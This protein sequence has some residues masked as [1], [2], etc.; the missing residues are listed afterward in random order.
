MV[1]SQLQRE[2]TPL[3]LRRN[4]RKEGKDKKQDEKFT[5]AVGTKIR[6]LPK[7]QNTTICRDL[8]LL[9]LLRSYKQKLGAN[10]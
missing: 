7:L 1:F 2:N 8:L 10:L 5:M 3:A 9:L 4:S 6:V